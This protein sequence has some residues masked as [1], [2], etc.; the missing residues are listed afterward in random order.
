[1]L[2][3]LTHPKAAGKLDQAPVT[4]TITTGQVRNAL[5]VPVAALLAQ[6]HGGYAVEVV[7]GGRH[8]LVKV[9]P[10]CSMTPPGWC[11]C[12]GPGCARAARRGARDMSTPAHDGRAGRRRGRRGPGGLVLELE[13]VTKIYPGRRR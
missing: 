13:A 6:P 7:A 3:S 9:T 8:H 4:V 12:P 5:V 1:M 11:R 10:G 2:V